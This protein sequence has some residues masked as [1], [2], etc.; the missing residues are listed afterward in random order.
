MTS[1][2]LALVLVL[3]A[4]VGLA[5]CGGD[6]DAGTT[7]GATQATGAPR[8]A[9]LDEPTK[10]TLVLDFVPNA[11][12]AGIYRAV[13]AGY[14]EQNN[15]DLEIIEP[16][17][18]ADTLKL[19]DAGKADFGI[20]DAIDVAG[21]IDAGA[22]AQGIL[23]LVQ[24][25][26][27]GL[28]ARK[29]SGITDP[30]QLEG[31]KVGVTGVPSDDVILDTVMR[32]AGGDPAKAEKVTIGFN[33]V[34]NLAGGSIDAF[35]GYWPADG[36]QVE[37]GGDPTTIFAFD[38]YGGP[39]YPGLVV[40]STTERVADDPELLAAFTDATVRG[41]DDTIEDPARSLDD[42]LAENR[43]LDREV[44]S[45]QLDAY[46]PLFL[47]DAEAFGGFDE[48]RL[49]G[50]SAFLREERLIERPI[51]PQRFATNAFVPAAE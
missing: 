22:D 33:G 34:Q 18:T 10:A 6:E 32:D 13:A 43:A 27:G 40:F 14:Y 11:V 9:A 31:R 29:S 15:L 48:Q 24:R 23:A 19:I 21:Q 46:G 42:L 28:V 1:R 17:S 36:V 4:A 37:V 38:E 35:T 5:A 51:S 3:L 45:A 26:L 41:Y 8:A 16:T 44:T 50:L 39:T 7:S 47:G 30:R 25:P 20:A 2:A 49:E 12:H